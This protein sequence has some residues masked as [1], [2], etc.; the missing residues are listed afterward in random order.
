M[1][2]P[3]RVRD[4]S[5]YSS[6]TKPC[7]S[8]RIS[9]PRSSSSDSSIVAKPEATPRVSAIGSITVSVALAFTEPPSPLPRPSSSTGTSTA[10]TTTHTPPS[11]AAS[12]RSRWLNGTP[13][14]MARAFDLTLQTRRSHRSRTFLPYSC[15]SSDATNRFGATARYASSTM[16][17]MSSQSTATSR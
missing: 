9:E 1:P 8:V 12:R 10:T 6:S 13:P 17:A 16:S 7:S 14:F 5:A 15:W 4:P 3:S 2:G 11:A